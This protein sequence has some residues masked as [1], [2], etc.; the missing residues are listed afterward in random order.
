MSVEGSVVCG[1]DINF[2]TCPLEAA[3]LGDIALDEEDLLMFKD[4]LRTESA[5]RNNAASG[6]A[7]LHTCWMDVMS[8][9]ERVSVLGIGQH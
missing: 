8:C 9:H 3:F 7:T 5:R 2:P 4:A 1:C 6:I